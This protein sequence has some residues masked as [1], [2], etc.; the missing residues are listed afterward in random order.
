LYR[1]S[2][3]I[4]LQFNG[5]VG[6]SQFTKLTIDA[7]SFMCPASLPFIIH[8][9]NGLGAECDANPAPLAPFSLNKHFSFLHFLSQLKPLL[10]IIDGRQPAG[11]QA[12][13]N[14]LSLTSLRG[15]PVGLTPG[16]P[17]KTVAL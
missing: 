5:H 15:F 16:E 7:F 9:Q 2:R 4:F 11:D 6:A 13:K 12:G 17:N 3:F 8:G 14:M 1:I 10:L